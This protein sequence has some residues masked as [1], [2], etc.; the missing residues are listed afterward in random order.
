MRDGVLDLLDGRRFA[1]E[2]LAELSAEFLNLL[3]GQRGKPPRRHIKAG[4]RP[5]DLTTLVRRSLTA[6]DRRANKVAER[7]AHRL[8]EVGAIVLT[9]VRHLAPS[10]ILPILR[11]IRLHLG[12]GNELYGISPPPAAVAEPT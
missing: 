8:F 2:G 3:R 11:A 4:H 12:R 6:R 1:I 10:G 9:R 5:H 7:F